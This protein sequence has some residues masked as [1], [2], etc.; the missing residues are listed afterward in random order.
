MQ[1]VFDDVS[2]L[3][4]I[5]PKHTY[6]WTNYITPWNSVFVFTLLD[7]SGEQCS[8]ERLDH[9]NANLTS[10]FQPKKENWGLSWEWHRLCKKKRKK[11]WC[12]LITYSWPKAFLVSATC[13][14]SQSSEVLKH[15]REKC[16]LFRILF[17]GW[18]RIWI[19]GCTN[20]VPMYGSHE[21]KLIYSH[22]YTPESSLQSLIPVG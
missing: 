22:W 15:Y 1:Y 17:I 8:S 12:N 11:N 21:F 16:L 10:L 14:F 4:L 2:N 6:I 19:W 9:Q 18:V 7:I 3:S 20:I 5:Y 13:S